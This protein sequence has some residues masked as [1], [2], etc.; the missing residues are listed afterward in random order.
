M[1]VALIFALLCFF[2]ARS[3]AED[4]YIYKDTQGKLVISNRQPPPG[5]NVIR[6]LDLPEYRDTQMQQVQENAD[7]RSTGK[8]EASPKQ[9]Q[10]K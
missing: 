4:H 10:K 6:K 9:D 1:T 3:H 8:L 5:S 7:M 2:A